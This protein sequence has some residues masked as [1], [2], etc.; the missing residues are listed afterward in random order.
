VEESSVAVRIA[1]SKE[2]ERI[3]AAYRGW[4]YGGGVERTD[5]VRLAES[6][7]ELIG[8][9]RVALESGTLV[10]RGMRIAEQW[11]RRGIGTRM[12]KTVAEWLGDRQ[13]YCVPYSHL[14]GFY[15]QIGFVGI[16]P[17]TVP[18]FLALRLAEYRHRSL[19]VVMMQRSAS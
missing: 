1:Q 3:I 12:L 14:T 15:G 2:I 8:V 13:C 6:E 17:S 5:T 18:S 9:V 19:D 11:Q 16:P 10:L 7:G 4:G